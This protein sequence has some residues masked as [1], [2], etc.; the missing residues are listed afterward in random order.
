MSSTA[1]LLR[2]TGLRATSPRMAILGW[3]ARQSRPIRVES[4][5]KKIKIRGIDRVTVY[6][7]LEA[8][9]QAGLVRQVDLGHGHAHYEINDLKRHH[10]HL[11]CESCGTVQDV[12]VSQESQL[13]QRF[14]RSHNFK[15][16]SHTFEMF[17][18]CAD[19]Q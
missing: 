1:I 19:C 7:T 3:L 4:V 16:R 8:L 13:I 2:Q 10:H 5:W 18:L 6:R 15:T 14:E 12:T 17:G 11:V 9:D